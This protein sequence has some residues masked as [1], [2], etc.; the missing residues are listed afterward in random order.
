LSK[1]LSTRARFLPPNCEKSTTPKQ[2]NTDSRKYDASR[3]VSKLTQE[4]KRLSGQK[5]DALCRVVEITQIVKKL[6]G[7][8]G[9]CGVFDGRVK[10][11]GWVYH[12][13]RILD[14]TWLHN[15]NEKAR[16]FGKIGKNQGLTIPGGWQRLPCRN[17][18]VVGAQPTGTPAKAEQSCVFF[19]H[20]ARKA[21]L[22]EQKCAQFTRTN[23]PTYTYPRKNQKYPHVV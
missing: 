20:R 2:K 19:A 3:Y 12:W 5:Y 15:S 7:Q 13:C 21:H 4:G 18:K 6:A 8:N 17:A 9:F 16:I 14:H 10:R 1:T 22:Y 23:Y 11:G